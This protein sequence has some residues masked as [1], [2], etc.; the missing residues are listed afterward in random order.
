MLVL[1]DLGLTADDPRIKGTCDLFFAQRFQPDGGFG[2]KAGHFC[3]TGNAAR[4]FV[5]FGY[6]DDP[7]IKRAF[8]WLVEKQKSDD[9]WHCFPSRYSTLDC[10]EALSAY[11][12]LPREKWTRSIKN[13]AERGAEYYLK[14][15]LWRQGGRRYEPWFRFH[16]PWHYYYDILVGLDIL[17][18]LGYEED[19]RLKT[20][21]KLLREKRRPDGKWIMDAVHPDIASDDPYQEPDAKLLIIEK[22]GEPSKWI[23]LLA[24]SVLKRVEGG[25]PSN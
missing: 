12:A 4:M 7:R 10:W 3:G 21:V 24:L 16:Y 8:N 23:T 18:S 25:L 1:S 22:P 17:T 13:S 20:A 11:G 2:M 15:K 6:A 9:G 19:H 5:R 14:H